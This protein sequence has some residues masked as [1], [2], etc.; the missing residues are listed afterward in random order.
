MAIPRHVSTEKVACKRY[1]ARSRRT[2]VTDTGRK[3]Y[4]TR[5]NRTA[6]ASMIWF[7][8]IRHGYEADAISAS[9]SVASTS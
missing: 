7:T 3:L 2:L 5:M 1:G 6:G 8:G 4:L 9:S